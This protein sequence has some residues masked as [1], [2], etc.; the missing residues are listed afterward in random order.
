ML[1]RVKKA[2]GKL[3]DQEGVGLDDFLSFYQVHI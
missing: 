1:K 3:E 2:F